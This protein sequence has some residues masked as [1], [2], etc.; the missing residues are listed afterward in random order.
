M[1]AETLAPVIPHPTL[2]DHLLAE[3]HAEIER[4]REQLHD[5]IEGV[6]LP[7]EIDPRM[8]YYGAKE[9]AIESVR[10][11]LQWAER[12]LAELEARLPCPDCHAP[13]GRSCGRRCTRFTDNNMGELK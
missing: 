7:E 4:R 9:D 1:S 13:A 6:I 11:S 12:E 3:Q 8:T 5:V 2:V 10:I